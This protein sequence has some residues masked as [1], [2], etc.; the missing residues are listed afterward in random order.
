MDFPSNE[1]EHLHTRLLSQC[2]DDREGYNSI[3]RQNVCERLFF[4]DAIRKSVL[5]CNKATWIVS[6]HLEQHDPKAAFMYLLKFS[7]KW[8][9][10]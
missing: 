7:T 3:K 9:K 6:K 1:L 4:F 10:A 5:P 8:S 2:T